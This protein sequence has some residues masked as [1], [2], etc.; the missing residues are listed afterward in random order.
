MAPHTQSAQNQ[1]NAQT[2][3]ET[4]RPEHS[5]NS[6]CE[7]KHY[8]LSPKNKSFE[9]KHVQTK[10]IHNSVCRNVC[11]CTCFKQK[12][13]F[14]MSQTR[15]PALNQTMSIRLRTHILIQEQER[16]QECE[17]F[18]SLEHS[19]STVSISHLPQQLASC[20]LPPSASS[21]VTCLTGHPDYWRSSTFLVSPPCNLTASLWSL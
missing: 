4:E 20:P 19:E 11:V 13:A 10:H 6:I 14:K 16:M 7:N 8:I 2:E 3:R 5:L 17:L 15:K 18:S 1:Q 9:Y 21:P 12:A